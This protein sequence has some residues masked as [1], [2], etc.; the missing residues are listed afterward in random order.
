MCSE[1]DRKER[2]EQ[3]APNIHDS[4][5][6]LEVHKHPTFMRSQVSHP[7]MTPFWPQWSS[8]QEMQM[9]PQL[10][11]RLTDETDICRDAR[12]C[13]FLTDRHV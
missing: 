7:E 10:L 1:L 12:S 4:V 5:N 9:K 13:I 2:K 6:T 8:A 11:I 3:D